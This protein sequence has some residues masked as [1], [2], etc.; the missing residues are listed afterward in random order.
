MIADNQTNFLYLA[1]TLP[2]NFPDFY[3]FLEKLLIRNKID[4]SLLPDTKDIWAR[5]YM[6]IQTDIH[7]FMQFVY[8]PSYLQ[9]K[10]YLNTISDTDKICADLDIRTIKSDIKIDGGNVVKGKNKVIMTDR[11]FEENPRYQR[12][13]LISELHE[14]LQV[15]KLYFLPEQPGDFRGHADGMVRFVDENSI[16]VND[17]GQENS[18]FRRVFE[19]AIHNTGLDYVKIPYNVYETK[20]TN[21]QTETILIT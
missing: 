18:R 14:L 1:D 2:K 6:P 7:N 19:V 11:I 9:F 21:K 3:Q 8:N 5:D 20:I 13:K 12:K 15:E 16:L 17:Y 4:Y 10:K